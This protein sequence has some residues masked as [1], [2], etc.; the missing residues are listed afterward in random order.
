MGQPAS[1]SAMSIVHSFPRPTVEPRLSQREEQQAW[2][3]KVWVG[4]GH[5]SSTGTQTVER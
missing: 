2:A 3:V 5:H 4:D 1:I